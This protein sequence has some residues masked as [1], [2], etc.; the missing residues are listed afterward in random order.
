MPNGRSFAGEGTTDD[1]YRNGTGDSYIQTET[2]AAAVRLELARR[3][4]SSTT[5]QLVESVR[6]SEA[7]ERRLETLQATL[8][9]QLEFV[10]KLKSLVQSSQARERELIAISRKALGSGHTP[11]ANP[12]VDVELPGAAEAT[13]GPVA[14]LSDAEIDLTERP[15]EEKVIADFLTTSEHA[16][17]IDRNRQDMITLSTPPYARFFRTRWSQRQSAELAD[18]Y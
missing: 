4:I 18:R 8:D 13:L 2:G 3:T 14:A 11:A 6:R 7:L 16:G 17:I 10:A 12:E 15:D 5:A 1:P 9:Q